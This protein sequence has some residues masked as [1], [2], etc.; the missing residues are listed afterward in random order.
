MAERRGVEL[1]R[2]IVSCILGRRGREE[3]Y[4][5]NV[6]VFHKSRL[7]SCEET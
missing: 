3:T 2:E 7:V 5:D 1:R 4:S 6:I